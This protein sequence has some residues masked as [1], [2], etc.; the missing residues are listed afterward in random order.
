MVDLALRALALAVY[1]ATQRE[2][3][4]A[5]KGAS[6]YAQLL[7]LVQGRIVQAGLSS[8]DKS[9]IGSCLLTIFL[10][11]RYEGSTHR[12][13]GT[14]SKA[15]FELLQTWSHHDGAMAILKLWYNTWRQEGASSIVRQTRR[16]CIKSHLLR[17]IDLPSWMLEGQP[18]GEDGLS[19]EYDSILVRLAK[20]HHAANALEQH[21]QPCISQ[22][23]KLDREGH[24]IDKALQEWVATFPLACSYQRCNLTEAKDLPKKHIY[25][26]IVYCYPDVADAALWSQYFATT[27]LLLNTCWRVLKLLR[28]D[29]AWK[30]QLLKRNR[31]LS[32]MADNLASSIPFCLDRVKVKNSRASEP[33]EDS[34]V[35]NREAMKPYSAGLVVWPLT[36]ASSLEGLDEKQQRWFRSELAEIGRITGDGGLECAETEQWVKL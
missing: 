5:T 19:L 23:E 3:A 34:V 22:I 29:M 14:N 13:G 15:P 27:M 10:M 25:S 35:L 7:Q 21:E 26:M 28:Q 8:L 1:S 36:L 24:E 16:G 33:A 2:S 20:F 31:R 32:D 9:D 6:K 30:E 11:S 4:A 18:F 12:P 17:N